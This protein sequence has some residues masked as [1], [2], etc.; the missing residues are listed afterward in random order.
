MFFDPEGRL[1]VLDVTHTKQQ[2]FRLIAVYA[3]AGSRQFDFFRNLEIFLVILKT[4]VL[5]GDFD[6]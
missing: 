6:V 4:L 2:S 1:V 5:L 3:P